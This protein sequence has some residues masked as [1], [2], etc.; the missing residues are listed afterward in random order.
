[1]HHT[2]GGIGHGKLASLM[3]CFAIQIDIH[4]FPTFILNGYW[5]MNSFHL[6]LHWPLR[7]RAD[8]SKYHSIA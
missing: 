5:L 7:R 6:A 4:H 8:E 3:L 1:M 2:D